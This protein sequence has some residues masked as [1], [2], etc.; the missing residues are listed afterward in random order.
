MRGNLYRLILFSLFILV[1]ATSLFSQEI[2]IEEVS[3]FTEKENDD[4][5]IFWE[6]QDFDVDENGNIYILD[7]RNGRIQK[8]AD[9]GKYLKTIGQRGSG[10]GELIYPDSI[11]ISDTKMFV[12]DPGNVRISTFTLEGKVIDSVTSGKFFASI[13]FD[14]EGNIYSRDKW[15]ISMGS[16]K[17]SVLAK[18]DSK[19]NFEFNIGEKVSWPMSAIKKRKRG[20]GSSISY[21]SLFSSNILSTIDKNN[22]VYVTYPYNSSQISKYSSSGNE[23][24]KIDPKMKRPKVGEE[25]R[26]F[27]LKKFTGYDSVNIPRHKPFIKLIN[28]DDDNKIWITTY[29]GE[30]K[31]EIHFHV[32]SEE[33]QFLYK[34]IVTAKNPRT[35][36]RIRIKKDNIYVFFYSQENGSKLIKYR[37]KE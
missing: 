24:L 12:Y 9:K 35:V 21:V 22:N 28:T 13:I 8:F 5:Y 15:P 11:R 23:L 6:P 1:A 10:P 29:D 18:Y 3:I 33:G 17:P 26:E 36:R 30:N 32:F 2:K 27:L 19:G 16:S 7:T 34:A 37:I 25:D 31:G 20:G 14:Y 4:N